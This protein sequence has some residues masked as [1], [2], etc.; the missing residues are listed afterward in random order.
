MTGAFVIGAQVM[1]SRRSI[2]VGAAAL[3]IAGPL[4]AKGLGAQGSG[5]DRYR[6]AMVIDGLSSIGNL[7][8]KAPGVRAQL[9]VF[10][11]SGLT[12]IN[13]TVGAAGN[14]PDRFGETLR[15]IARYERF[16][17]AFPDRLLHV[18]SAADL[19]LA[20]DS[21]RLGV[22]FGFQDCVP[23]ETEIDRL[24]LFDQLGVRII[25]LTYNKRNLVGDG[26]LETA[27]GGLS[28]Y[29]REVVAGLNARRIMVDTSHAGARTIADAIAAST[30]P[31]AISH[32]GCRALVDVPR[33]T[34]DA[35]FR[36]LADKGGVAGIYFMPFLRAA[37]QPRGEDVIRHI[38]HAVK[39]AGEDHVSLG[40]DGGI[41]AAPTGAAALAEQRQFYDERKALGV[42]APG[43]APDVLNIVPDYNEPTRFLRLAD[44]L[45]ARRWPERRIEKLLG[46]NF[47][48]LCADV[49]G[50]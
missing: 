47:A 21:N 24:D 41:R 23:L 7:D 44:D 1:P 36:A 27:N 3:A 11:A 20:Q 28:D 10:R 19:K 12:A 18:R 6:R 22:I 25:Q 38:E 31:I 16:I 33:N 40:T 37:G 35:E 8:P 50:G 17:R 13:Q 30:A 29:G 49:W 9:D 15:R 42:A 5:A 48:R 2:L 14:T 26:C 43:E 32:T 4:G 39:V 46:G 45:A 34:P